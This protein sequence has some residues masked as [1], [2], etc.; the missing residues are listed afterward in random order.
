[1]TP[2]G[3]LELNPRCTSSSVELRRRAPYTFCPSRTSSAMRRGMSSRSAC[4]YV[5]LP[6]SVSISTPRGL[7]SSAANRAVRLHLRDRAR[8]RG[9]GR[10]GSG[11]HLERWRP[12]AARIRRPAAA[13]ARSGTTPSDLGPDREAHHHVVSAHHGRSRELAAGSFSSNRAPVELAER[14]AQQL[15]RPYTVAASIERAADAPIRS[16]HRARGIRRDRGAP[17]RDNA[18]QL[19]RPRRPARRG[20]WNR[21]DPGS[22]LGGRW[23]IAQAFEERDQV[24][25]IHRRLDVGGQ[26]RSSG[27]RPRAVG[28]HG[29]HQR[30]E[31]DNHG[32]PRWV[33]PRHRSTLS[34]SG[35]LEF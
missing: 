24:E 27:R 21:T 8:P 2:K 11:S 7:A 35:R 9:I 34:R 12:G 32:P 31:D 5:R 18:W 25:E 10:A 13:R 16:L 19:C 28:Q 14:S 15:P 22:E 4:G 30:G 3:A 23:S 33:R 17:R 20:G 29:S 6:P 26:R 1:M